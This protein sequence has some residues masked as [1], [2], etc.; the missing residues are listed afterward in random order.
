MGR[1]WSISEKGKLN[2]FANEH[3]TK[4]WD[5]IASEL[6]RTPSDCRKHYYALNEDQIPRRNRNLRVP[7]SHQPLEDRQQNNNADP[8]K[9]TIPR[10]FSNISINFI[11]NRNYKME[12]TY[13]LDGV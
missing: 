1:P 12:I 6:G 13:I 9:L 2:N 10:Q 5:P 7:R 4:L 3:G 8:V 11:L